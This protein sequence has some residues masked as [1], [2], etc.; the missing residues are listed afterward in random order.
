MLDFFEIIRRAL[1]GPY[2]SEQDF[3][4]KVV[5]PKLRQVVKKYGIRW[6]GKTPVSNDDQLADDVFQAALE[7]CVD[8]GSYCTD[9][10]R[11]IRVTKE[12]LLEALR[13]APAAPVFGEGRDRKVMVARK[14]ESTIPPWCYVGAGGATCSSEDVFVRLVEGYGRNPLSDSITCPTLTKINGLDIETG[15]PLELLACIRSVE[16]ARAA[17]R[18]AQRPGL[19]IMNSI[20][21]AVTDTAKIA[22][23]EF[24]LRD[25]DCWVIG[26]SAEF[27][28]K[29][30]RM[31]EVAYILSRGAQLLGEAGP[32]LGGYA[33]GQEGVA[34]MSV[35]YLLYAILVLRAS[36]HLNVPVDLR[37]CS[38]GR[39]LLWAQSVA[40]QAIS[41]NSH[42]PLLYYTY[43]AAGPMTEMNLREI[44][45]G[46]IT[47]VVS[48]GN[49]E[50]GGVGAAKNMDHLSPVEPQ[51]ATQVAHAAV[52]M[53]RAHANEIVHNLLLSYE[54]QLANP[55]KG[56]PFQESHDWDSITP[57]QEY[58]DLVG[59]IKDELRGYGLKID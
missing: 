9:T 11:V 13:D 34:V 18:R 22:A 37:G 58:K 28:V 15:S 2:Y 21:T 10:N 17:L 41:R 54:N 14:P 3:D 53:S 16:L 1:N 27:K 55:P 30:A 23:S 7:L 39:S 57:C 8:T 46:M 24:G 49:I 38:S 59:K 6:D 26:F 45:A 40:T 56:T 42:L 36:C 25:S 44:A 5:V 19:P 52:G 51:F 4:M 48:G 43:C 35:A 31:N 29:F 32:I 12:E 33:G 20:A 47:G 50:F